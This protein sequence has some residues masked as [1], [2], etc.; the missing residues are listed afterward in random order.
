MEWF[1]LQYMSACY[2]PACYRLRLVNGDGQPI[3]I[4]SL[5][6]GNPSGV[7]NIGETENF[8]QR[9]GD[10]LRGVTRAEGHSAGN[11]FRYL[12][13]FGGLHDSHPG[14]RL[15]YSYHPAPSKVVAGEWEASAMKEYIIRFG[16]L[17]LLNRQL[18]K[19]YDDTTWN[20]LWD[21]IRGE[22]GGALLHFA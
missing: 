8:E 2:A 10:L 19:A 5:T 12:C 14:C 9:R 15:Q 7:V 16:M 17:P 20:A 6:G 18:P 22:G 3:P 4:P 1:E 13:L 11:L 21:A